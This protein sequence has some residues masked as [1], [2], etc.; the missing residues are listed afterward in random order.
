MKNEGRPV[1]VNGSMTGL[2]ENIEGTFIEFGQRAYLTDNGK[3]F[4]ITQAIIEQKGTGKIRMVNPEAV[5]FTD[6]G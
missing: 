3:D 4:G 5:T 2:M 6:V 1:R